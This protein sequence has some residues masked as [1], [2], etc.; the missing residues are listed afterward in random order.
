MDGRRDS[1]SAFSS[2]WWGIVL[3]VAGTAILVGSFLGY[4][5]SAS[6]VYSQVEVSFSPSE[7][8]RDVN[9]SIHRM[10]DAN[11]HSVSFKIHF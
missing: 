1:L 5:L 2:G 6:P 3:G 8:A 7:N 4:H 9:A 10:I 11:N